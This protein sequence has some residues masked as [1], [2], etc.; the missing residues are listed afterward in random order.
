MKFTDHLLYIFLK[1]KE[2]AENN[3]LIDIMLDFLHSNF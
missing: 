2:M 3:R 1:L